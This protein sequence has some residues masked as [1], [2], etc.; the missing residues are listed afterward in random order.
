MNRITDRPTMIIT[1]PSA[2]RMPAPEAPGAGARPAR[3]GRG[4][5][6]VRLVVLPSS[7]PW[8][9]DLA[10]GAAVRVEA[11]GPGLLALVLR[12]L[13]PADHHRVPVVEG[14][15]CPGAQAVAPGLD[16]PHPGWH[17][18]LPELVPVDPVGLVGE[19]PS[20]GLPGVGIS[21]G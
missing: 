6:A 11:E 8:G 18:E 20:P 15:E 12:P 16:V 2:S 19:G 13:A 10:P 14:D 5:G 17:A 21:P 4:V 9:L 1:D 7:E 3:P